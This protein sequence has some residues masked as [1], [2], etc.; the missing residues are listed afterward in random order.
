MVRQTPFKSAAQKP[1]AAQDKKRKAATLGGDSTCMQRLEA[2]DIDA[3]GVATRRKRTRTEEQ[4]LQKVLNDNFPGF[5]DEELFMNRIQGKTL[6]ERI[7]HDRNRVAKGDRITMGKMYYATLR[8]L[9]RSPNSAHARLQVQDDSMPQDES[10]IEA[11]VCLVQTRRSVMEIITWSETASEV[12]QM[13][14]VALL[15]Q[16]LKIPPQKSLENCSI[17]VALMR[18]IVR[19][20]LHT[21]FPNEM[22]AMR[23]HF[24]SACCKSLASFKSQMR[25]GSEWWTMNRE[26][27]KLVLP[28]QATNVALAEKN[29]LAQVDAEINMVVESSEVGRRL[30]EAAMRQVQLDKIAGRIAEHV[31]ELT[32][33][34]LTAAILEKN[35]TDFM[36]CLENNGYN[37]LQR[38]TPKQVEY[39]YRG[40]KVS[41]V[42]TS[43]IE[44]YSVAVEC[45]LRSVATD[46]GILPSLWCENDLVGERPQQTIKLAKAMVA[47]SEM[48]RHTLLDQ[49]DVEDATSE[50]IMRVLKE[51]RA[52]LASTDRY[53]KIEVAFWSSLVGEAAVSK[54]HELILD[55][56]PNRETVRSL[57]QSHQ[58][59]TKAESSA[60]VSFCGSALKS[61][62]KTVHNYIRAMQSGEAPMLDNLAATD[63]F[64]ANVKQRLAFFCRV[65][66]PKSKEQEEMVLL[67]VDAAKHLLQGL[68]Q[69]QESN[70]QVSFADIVSVV[71]FKWLLTTEERTR[72]DRIKNECVAKSG[73]GSAPCG[74]TRRRAS[75]KKAGVD[76]RSMVKALFTNRTT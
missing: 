11:L 59:L 1:R 48:T 72:L 10:L 13:N 39:E 53:S 22:L 68:E 75:T 19:L 67:G 54:V 6:P 58:K 17:T 42:V 40:H 4:A 5:S 9:Y 37:P 24:D 60:L 25:S 56:L 2:E 29:S 33:K 3:Q 66:L 41:I 71:T 61:V 16:V 31:K 76:T 57:E 63:A 14:F 34:S 46:L 8:D 27:A 55:C 64:A 62:V 12:N 21:K 30:L 44:Q 7:Q 15:K 36:K 43:P 18:M 26:W 50:N 32:G 52:F 49:L 51:K 35:K 70:A 20:D 28:M 23:S 45:L 69:K 65:T 73:A 47:P 38:F 74:E